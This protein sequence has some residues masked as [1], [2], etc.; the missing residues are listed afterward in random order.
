MTTVLTAV[1]TAPPP[2]VPTALPAAE[3]AT[4]PEPAKPRPD[5]NPHSANH[6]RRGQSY[7]RA[8][9][10]NKAA[11]EF[12][13]AA[14]KSP[15]DAQLW[16]QLAR[17]RVQ[18]GDYE[19]G[20]DAARRAIALE[21]PC[22]AALEL[23]AHCLER[24]GRERDLVE[25][26]SSIDCKSVNSAGLHLR[27]G[28]AFSRL[29]RFQEAVAAIFEALK[30]NPRFAAA[31]GQLGNVFQLMKMPEEA[32]ESF[33]NALALGYSP[34]EMAAAIVFNS[35]EA[36]AW[37]SVADDLAALGELVA[38]GRGHPVPFFC[39][40][41]SWTRQQQLAASRAKAARLFQ[42]IAPLPA[43]AKRRAGARIRIGY[44]SSDLHEHA[45]A[46]LIAEVFE[47]HDKERFETYAYS[48]GE[49]DGSAMRRRIE[50]AFGANFV[51]ARELSSAA[52]ARR[53][54]E[55]A[56]DVL[57][58]LK[59]YTLYAR[60]EVFAYRAAPIQVNFLGFPGSLGSENYQYIIG[61]RT[62]TPLAH[63]DGFAEKI[64]Q[65]PNCYQPNDRQRVIGPPA[66][67]ADC[68]LPQDAF[69]L[70]CLNA[71][72]KITPPVFD[73]WCSLLRRI[74][75]AVL[76]LYAANPQARKNI[77]AQLQ[78]RGFDPG[79]LFWAANLP[80]GAHLARMQNADLFLD[81]LP[82]N[83]HTTASDALWAGVPVLT[84][85]GESF[86]SR[87]AASLLAAAGI[88][89]L[90][91]H[92]LDEYERLACELAADRGRLR[93]V[94]Q[95]LI[96]SRDSCAL[97]D[98]ARYTRDFEALIDRMVERHD[99]GLAPEHLGAAAC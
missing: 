10:W 63:A 35:L 57:V 83:A 14:E 31:F 94:R 48:Y 96:G 93:T 51:E 39:L 98:S 22:E 88:P 17:A 6:A 12:A 24:A 58:D 64:A 19:G 90:V 61:D 45:T 5:A 76:W 71:N 68:G 95:R 80:L 49:N 27:L 60:N 72:Y 30:R 36:S 21:P 26:F 56:I 40:N 91:A 70:C 41:F 4:A 50:Q 3:S 9:R 46:Y 16:V 75:D 89:E 37:G 52:L 2:A 8:G 42:G 84:V 54:R 99:R 82:V 73:R 69:V 13:C 81:T 33:R 74:D 25:L 59:G 15:T 55:D 43:R 92:D 65:L 1:L 78:R 38:G 11:R 86:V 44:V 79:R 87:V 67:R 20:N 62:V 53:I 18:I 28:I 29:G 47:R 77:L 85:L 97:F 7:A 32:R 34:V 66:S 23:A